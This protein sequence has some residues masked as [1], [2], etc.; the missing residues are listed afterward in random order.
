MCIHVNK[1]YIY[2]R[3]HLAYYTK[4]S[5]LNS[6][7]SPKDMCFSHFLTVDNTNASRKTAKQRQNNSRTTGKICHFEKF[8]R[9]KERGHRNLSGEKDAGHYY[10]A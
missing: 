6:Y 4:S 8:A 5:T 9:Q 7:Y 2:I 1:L 3:Y 10:S